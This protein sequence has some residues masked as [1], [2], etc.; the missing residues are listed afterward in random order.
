MFLH[1]YI[2]TYIHLYSKI[3]K[4]RVWRLNLY[5]NSP[6][7]IRVKCIKI[8]YTQRKKE[9]N[10]DYLNYDKK[11]ENQSNV[12]ILKMISILI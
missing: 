11:E 6:E 5:Y 12:I 3:L 2:H 4:R 10:L 1:V 7:K 8:M 9:K